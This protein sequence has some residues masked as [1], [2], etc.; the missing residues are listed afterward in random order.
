MIYFYEDVLQW[1]EAASTRKIFLDFN[2]PIS[3][4]RF[5]DVNRKQNESMPKA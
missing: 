3:Q 4:K 2:F 1:K 5:L